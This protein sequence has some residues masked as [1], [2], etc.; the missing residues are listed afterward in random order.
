M[1]STTTTRI[2]ATSGPFLKD[3]RQG[4]SA[5]QKTLPSKYLYDQRGSQLFEEICELE[6]YYPTRTELAIMEA[7]VD[8]MRASVGPEHVVLELGSGASLKTRLL[9]HAIDRPAAYVPLDISQSALDEAVLMLRREFPD[10]TIAPVCGD[11]M[12]EIRLPELPVDYHG[13]VTYFPGSTIGNLNHRNAVA[14]LQRIRRV[15]AESDLLIGIDLEKDRRVLLEAYDDRKGVT[16]AFN[17]NLLKRINKELAGD[18]DLEQFAHQ[19]I[20]NE[21]AHRIEMHL[22]SQVDQTVRIAGEEFEFAQG[23]SICTE[24]S[25]KYTVE[26]FAELAAEADFAVSN[27]WTDDRRLFAVLLLTPADQSPGTE[28]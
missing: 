10:L 26:R 21:Q 13:V 3:V 22:V 15:D 12:D 20:Y 2:A 1:S 28:V 23:E 27:V 9:L 17:L 14:L 25:H 8:N 16:A 4:L 11:F 5:V 7:H 24:H 18:F 6:E 19:A